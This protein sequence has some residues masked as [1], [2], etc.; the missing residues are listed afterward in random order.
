MNTTKK[1]DAE[2]SFLFAERGFAY[3]ELGEDENAQA[4][5]RRAMKLNPQCAKIYYER[6]RYAPTRRAL[7]ARDTKTIQLDPDYSGAYNHRGMENCKLGRYDEAIADL[8]KA[9]ELKPSDSN[10]WRWRGKTYVQMEE[11]DNAQED[12]TK[13]VETGALMHLALK[14]S[15]IAY[16]NEGQYEKALE[17]YRRALEVQPNDGLPW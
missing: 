5:W 12:F 2:D 9:V 8:S 13:A 11:Y 16:T 7:V 14:E 6:G 17:Q 15:G 10:A 1:P 4:D 3:S